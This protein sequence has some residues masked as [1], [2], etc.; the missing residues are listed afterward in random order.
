MALKKENNRWTE[1]SKDTLEI[2]IETPFVDQEAITN[3][4]ETMNVSSGHKRM[5]SKKL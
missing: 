5:D 3:H 1:A 2:L 4:P